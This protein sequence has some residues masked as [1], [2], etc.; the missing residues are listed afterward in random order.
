MFSMKA[1]SVMISVKDPYESSLPWS[2]TTFF[3]EVGDANE[4][5]DNYDDYTYEEDYEEAKVSK[6]DDAK[7]VVPSL[8]AAPRCVRK[9]N[10]SVI[11]A[12]PPVFRLPQAEMQQ[13]AAGHLG[14]RVELFC[15]HRKGCPRA[16][17]TW[18]KDGKELEKRGRKSGLSTQDEAE[19]GACR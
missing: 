8:R 2:S 1:S 7:N 19:W 9:K 16:K 18:T 11:K 4:G 13:L 12:S 17:V 15:P 14:H 3:E 6:R 10:K 5:N